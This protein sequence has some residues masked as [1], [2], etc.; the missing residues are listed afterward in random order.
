MRRTDPEMT[1]RL[2]EEIFR[3]GLGNVELAQKIGC[4]PNTICLW[5]SGRGV[6]YAWYL[7]RLYEVGC[8]IIY[9]LTGERTRGGDTRA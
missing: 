2:A 8:D 3:L 1:M 7:A 6:P 9:I 5:T 4:E